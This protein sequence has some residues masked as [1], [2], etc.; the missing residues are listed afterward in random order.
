MISWEI[1]GAFLF[2]RLARAALVELDAD[3]HPAIL[4]RFVV[5]CRSRELS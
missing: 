4:A 2:L 3:I 5:V 1:I